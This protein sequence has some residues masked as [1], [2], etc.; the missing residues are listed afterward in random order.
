MIGFCP[1]ADVTS[2]SEGT[3]NRCEGVKFLKSLPKNTPRQSP[4]VFDRDIVRTGAKA[5]QLG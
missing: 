2:F 5:A 4:T 3:I 1:Y